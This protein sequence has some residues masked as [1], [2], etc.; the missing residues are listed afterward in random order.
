MRIKIRLKE[1]LEQR[2][3]TSRELA[4]QLGLSANAISEISRMKVRSMNLE[5]LRKICEYL[6]CQPGD[7]IVLE[8]EDSG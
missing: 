5:T 2:G 1:V 8:N 7:I 6:D 4:E 3:V